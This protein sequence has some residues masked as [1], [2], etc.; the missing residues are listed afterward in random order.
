MVWEGGDSRNGLGTIEGPSLSK[1]KAIGFLAAAAEEFASLG[2]FSRAVLPM[3]PPCIILPGESRMPAV[4][5][6]TAMWVA[7]L[8]ASREASMI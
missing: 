4:T 3:I 7:S 8:L 1:R 5:G 6:A 2:L